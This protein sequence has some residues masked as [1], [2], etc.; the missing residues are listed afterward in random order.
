M[1]NLSSKLLKRQIISMEI[2]YADH[3][4][5]FSGILP[6]VVMHFCAYFDFATLQAHI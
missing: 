4:G 2:G 3:S 1:E 6:S 5:F